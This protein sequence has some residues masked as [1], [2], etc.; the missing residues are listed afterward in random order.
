MLFKNDCRAI[1][2][3]LWD[4]AGRQLGESDIE[5]IEV[6][7][8]RC[9]RCR[10]EVE[11]C[12]AAISVVDS[13]RA[14]EPPDSNTTW[15][16]LR[17]AI[18]SDQ[19]AANR[20][21]RRSLVPAFALAGAAAAFS[22]IVIANSRGLL[23]T[24]RSGDDDLVKMTNVT[25]KTAPSVA[26]KSVE[27]SR[28]APIFLQPQHPAYNGAGITEASERRPIDESSHGTNRLQVVHNP[29][30]V[31]RATNPGASAGDPDKRLG[32]RPKR[33]FVMPPVNLNGPNAP[34]RQFVMGSIPRP[35]SGI[36]PASYTAA[37][38]EAPVW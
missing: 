3:L 26:S 4:Y 13:V 23:S 35:E 1:A 2:P 37:S 5:R 15:S 7:L 22:I 18:E 32:Q 25:P 36:T 19:T 28:P 33:D 34:E 6:H 9:D 24:Q 21:A 14:S 29:E 27:D 38:E 12:L 20:P 11:S 31:Q 8:E 10:Q 30:K 17:F 16:A